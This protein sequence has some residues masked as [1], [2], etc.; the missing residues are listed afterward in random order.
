MERDTIERLA[1]D[2]AL[3]E[4][5]PDTT[6]LFD[7]YLAEH[8]E[9]ERWARPMTKTC[10]RT[11]EA[12]VRKTQTHAAIPWPKPARL[13]PIHRAAIVRW[14]AV[15]AV[16]ALLGVTV[17]RWSRP[18]QPAGPGA[19]V[20]RTVEPDTG[21]EGWRKILNEPEQGFWQTKAVAMLQSQ[22]N[23]IPR[24]TDSG[25]GLWDRYR[26]FRKERSRE[27]VY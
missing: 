26:Q 1:I 13:L 5:D 20:V 25:P 4:L 19:V 21:P 3:G 12:I 6:M 11:R 9:A 23:E 10:D 17:G 27:E 14:A 18:P 16:S 8:P 24:P 2:R 7:T 15:I 22:P